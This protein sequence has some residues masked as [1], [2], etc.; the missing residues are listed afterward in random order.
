MD[1]INIKVTKAEL[2]D[3]LGGI[4]C[5]LS[6]CDMEEPG[7]EALYTKLEGYQA[8]TQKTE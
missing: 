3:L 5:L 2:A 1:E 4:G 6:E 8:Q 7:W